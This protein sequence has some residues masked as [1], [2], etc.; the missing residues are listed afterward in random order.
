MH[1]P[2]IDELAK[3]LLDHSCELQ[4]GETILIEAIDLPD[5]QLVCALVEGA[6]ERGA[7]PL[8]ELKNLRVQRTL[9]DGATET[10]MKLAGSLERHRMEQVQAYIGVR[11]SA[12]KLTSTQKTPPL[13]SSTKVRIAQPSGEKK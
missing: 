2:R 4:S 1:D 8:V 10:G 3:V 6:A 11:G 13:T 7:T 5:P 12:K 9:L